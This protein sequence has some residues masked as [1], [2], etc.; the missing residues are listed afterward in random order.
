MYPRDFLIS[1]KRKAL[2][3]GIWF[4]AL[5]SLDRGYYNLVCIV[6]NRVR[7]E[8]LAR[9]VMV[10]L[11]KLRDALK[12]DFVRLVEFYGVKRAWRASDLAMRWGNRDAVEW[13]GEGGFARF[14]AMIEFNAPSGGGI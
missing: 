11:L 12:S 4:K 10:I 6:V 9:E 1:V 14:H 5:S 13:K 3:R 2:R 7:S 8:A